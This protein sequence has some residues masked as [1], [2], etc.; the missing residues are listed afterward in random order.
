MKIGAMVFGKVSKDGSAL[1]P[2]CAE[3]DEELRS[4]RHSCCEDSR[5]R[6][7]SV[8]SAEA[9]YPES[10]YIGCHGF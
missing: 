9:L 10:L 6:W 8:G 4:G 1:I 2:G 7:T 3:D 5:V